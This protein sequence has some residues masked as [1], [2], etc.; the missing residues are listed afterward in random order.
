MP[1]AAI[2][3][4]IAVCMAEYMADCMPDAILSV[5]S[6]SNDTGASVRSHWCDAYRPL[7]CCHASSVL[8]FIDSSCVR[9]LRVWRCDRCIRSSGR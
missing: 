4:A 8:L 5:K 1:A 6:V 9:A 2:C 3:S 7:V